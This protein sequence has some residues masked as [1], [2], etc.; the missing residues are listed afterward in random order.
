MLGKK[1]VVAGAT[2]SVGRLIVKTCIDDPRIDKV[3]AVVRKTVSNEK[4]EQLWGAGDTSNKDNGPT[5]ATKMQKLTQI[6]V[7]YSAL[8]VKDEKL[9]TAFQNTDAFLTGLG[10]YSGNAT[11]AEMDQVEGSYNQI[12]ATIAHA[13][14]AKRGA[15]LS[16]QGVKQPSTEG[17]AFV[18]FGRAKGRAEEGLAKIFHGEDEAHVS[19]RPGGIFDRPGEPVYGGAI[20]SMMNSWPFSSLKET[21]FG[22]SAHLIAK[23]MVQGALFDDRTHVNGNTIWENEDI[24]EAAHRYEE[25]FENQ[26]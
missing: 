6:Q 3:T 19:V 16:G 2:G 21:R 14:G 11:E 1:V 18:M 26:E 5:T 7:D 17:R 15:Y 12:L 4:A 24:R 13:E 25:F 8:D 9:K 22:I 10:L 23:G 20:E